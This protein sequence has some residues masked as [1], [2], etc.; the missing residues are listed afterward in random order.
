MGFDR[1]RIKENAKTHYQNNKWQNVLVVLISMLIG[2]GVS[3]VFQF[4]GKIPLVGIFMGLV[5]IAVSLL[6]TSIISMGTTTWFHRS[7]KTEGLKMEEMFW[8]FKEDYGGNVLLVFLIGLY[9]FLWSLLFFVPGIVKGYSYSLALYI[10]SENPNI[11]PDK[12]I[13]L[14]KKMTNGRKMDLFVLDLSYIGWFILSALTFNILG[15]LY[16]IPYYN[17]AKAFAYEEIKEEAL[18]KMVVTEEEIYGY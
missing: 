10:K 14:S 5:S 6:F 18:S 11:K 7:I 17:A 4:T 1:I 16:V 15:V 13:D 8:A 12:A 3:V 2:G 9:T